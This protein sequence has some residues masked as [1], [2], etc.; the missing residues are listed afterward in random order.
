MSH[1]LVLA[2]LVA[3]S[4]TTAASAADAP[5]PRHP[6]P[7][8]DGATIAFSWQGDLWLVPVSGGDARRL[9]AHPASERYPV[10]SRDGRHIAFASDRHG[11]PDVFVMPADGSE[12]PRRL[13]HASTSDLP[14]DFTPDGTAVLF[15]SNRAMGIR[16]MPQLWTV[17]T[18]GG[19]PALAGPAFAEQAS[20][21]P[22]GG[23]TVIVRGATPWTRRGYRGAAN[24][25]LWLATA[26]GDYRRLTDFAGDDD[27]PSWIDDGALSFLSSRNG[28]KNV[29]RLDLATFEATALTD[30]QVADVRFP[31]AAANGSVIAYEAE[32][33]LWVVSP[34]GGEP[35]RLAISVPSDQL[36]NQVDRR[37][38]RKGATDLAIHP[39]G[40]LAAFIVHGDLFVTAVVSKDDL[41]IAEPPTVQ[42]T[43]TPERE[44]EPRWT[45]DGK[46]LLVTA[47]RGGNLDLVSVA[48]ADAGVDWTD[49]F[50]FTLSDLVAGPENERDPR[51]SPDGKRLAFV[52]GRGTLVVA[53]AD[54]ANQ[55]TLLDHFYPPT[56]SWSPDG[57]WIAYAVEDQH[58]NSE[59]FIVSADGGEPYNVSRHPDFDE[60]PVWT[61]DGRRLLWSSHRHGNSFDVWGVWLTE[62]DHQRTPAD[63]LKVWN[64]DEPEEEEEAET[65]EE[66]DAGDEDDTDEPDLPTVVIDFDEL[67]RRP[68]RLTSLDGDETPVVAGPDGKRIVFVGDVEEESDLYSIRFDGDD[69][70]RLTEDDAGPEQVQLVDG[71]TLFF[72]DGDGAVKRLGLDGDAGDPVPFTARYE[73][74]LRRE[75]EVVF[76]EAWAAL[77]EHFYD[78]DFHGVDWPAVRETYRPWA[79][80]ASSEPDFADVMN[81]MLGELDA[82]HMGYYPRGRG[83]EPVGDRTGWIGVVFDP[84]AGGPGLLVAE[85]LPD[86]P[87]DHAGVDIAAGERVLSVRGRTLETDTNVFELLVDTIGQ[88]VPL[89]VRGV[90]GAVR[91]VVVR[92]VAEGELEQ[93]RY[94]EWVRQ[95]RALVDGWSAGRLGYLHIQGMDL[96][97]FEDFE[98]D[99]FAA[100]DGKEGLIIDVRSNG[101]GWTT[102]YLMA[103]LDVRRHAYTLPR[104]GDPNIRSYPTSERLP[105]AAYTR[106]AAALCNEDSYSNA[107]IFSWAF[108]TLGRGP[109][110]GSPTF[111]AVISTGGTRL[112]NGAWVRLPG[113][114][115]FVAGSGV[116]MERNGAQPDVVVWQPPAEDSSATA[117]TQLETAVR[118]RLDGIEDD[119]RYGAW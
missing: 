92:P 12:P 6:A 50:A 75:R 33:G 61:P 25:E 103:V 98:R 44:Q 108:Q 85:V 100:A 38:D 68:I 10:W 111:G 49:A 4:A 58:A 107:E 71:E 60:A 90:D 77:D 24:R 22:D 9:T 105:M 97:S 96:P 94:R 15:A 109:L 5:L 28:R 8:P 40:K 86:S 31:R 93:L 29:F 82:S 42:A 87:A 57:R 27:S 54:G 80:A 35:R 79:L 43:S 19:T 7:S 110:I 34:T 36:V 89:A 106:P 1:R 72:L 114:G 83:A 47:A 39:D 99:L 17:P 104:A 117:D 21:S 101:G 76:D 78:P 26:A 113:R 62:A 112:L 115:W 32:D 16:W 59:I 119:P 91:D 64:G 65:D 52:R 45:P 56:Y 95:R 69:L 18:T 67:W 102:D 2:V 23:S 20:I 118:V 66:D 73:V 70:E 116:N 3:L 51:F 55:R 13:T 74:D 11:N 63:W 48:R 88:R 30:H 14:L 53:D 37:V 46:S 84:A 41:E 81:L